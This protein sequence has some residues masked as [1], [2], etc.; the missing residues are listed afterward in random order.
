MTNRS[1][2]WCMNTNYGRYVFV[3]VITRPT[4]QTAVNM[5]VITMLSCH[6]EDGDDCSVT[7]MMTLHVYSS[8]LNDDIAGVWYLAW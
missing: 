4:I 6:G 8:R 7:W 5:I 2:D 3:C 1:V